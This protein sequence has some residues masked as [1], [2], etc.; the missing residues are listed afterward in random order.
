MEIFIILMEI[1]GTVAFAISGAMVAV[2]KNMDI[3]GIIILGITTAVG[4]GVIRD[5][6]LGNTPPQTFRNPTYPLIAIITSLIVFLFLYVYK[7]RREHENLKKW[8]EKSLIVFDAIGLGIFTTVGISVAMQT[9]ETSNWFL[10]LFVGVITG[11]GGGILRDILA[12]DTPYILVKHIYACASI[13]GAIICIGLW[14]IVGKTISM[15]IGTV[16]VIIIRLLA[17]H[18]KWNLPK[19]KQ[20]IQ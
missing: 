13:A 6:I 20:N 1:V 11:V 14:N 16:V 19:I 8:Y 10:C 15:L 12:D 3:L 4:G 7:K 2:K 18:Y 9:N 5:I 17:A